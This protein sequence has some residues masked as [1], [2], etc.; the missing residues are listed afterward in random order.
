MS[1]EIFLL[2]KGARITVQLFDKIKKEVKPGAREK[3]I[4]QKLESLMC[5]KGFKRSFTTII[6]SG[7]NAANPHA[8][9]TARRIKKNDIVV[10]DFGII[11]KGYHTDMTRTVVVGKINSRLKLLYGVVRTAQKKAIK[12]IKAGIK[13]SLL[14]KEAHDHM[15]G[16]GFGKYILHSLGHGVGLRIHQPPKISEKNNRILKKGVVCT[17]EPG[18]Y[19]KGLGGARIE[20]MVLVKEKGCEVFTK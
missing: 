15:R 1:R 16:K 9:I 18:L 13:L 3:N 6:A 2:R 7:P 14:A 12:K 11:Y 17:I 8:K 5:E 19:I 4:A 20:D 10:V